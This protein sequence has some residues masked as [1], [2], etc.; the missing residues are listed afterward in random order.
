[1]CH[2]YLLPQ[3]MTRQQL[4]L[5]VPGGAQLAGK[6]AGS[7][8]WAGKAPAVPCSGCLGCSLGESRDQ[9]LKLQQECAPG[10]PP[11]QSQAEAT[12]GCVLPD[13]FCAS[14]A[15]AAA[16]RPSSSRQHRAC[17][18]PSASLQPQHGPVR[19]S[20]P[21]GPSSHLI[22]ER[23]FDLLV[24]EASLLSLGG[25]GLLGLQELLGFAPLGELGRFQELSRGVP[26]PLLL[27]SAVFFF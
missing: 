6:R 1:M 18:S 26:F 16:T 4:A 27:F 14:P 8:L 13:R 5:E 10:E 9:P 17:S 21:R 15:P 25:C 24:S 23:Q 11:T 7:M 19:S 20:D 12:A 3:L 22:Q 2:F